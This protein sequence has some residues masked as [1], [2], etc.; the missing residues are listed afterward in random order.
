MVLPGQRDH[1]Q[2]GQLVHGRLGP[3]RI[4]RCVPDHEFERP[5]AD[6]TGVVDLA[7][8]P[9]DPGQQVLTRLDPAG[10]RQRN[11]NTDP[12]GRS[13]RPIRCGR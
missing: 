4:R 12:H 1:S 8:A 7:D 11:E 3:V 5:A 10:S 13:A 9:L 2:P 6:A